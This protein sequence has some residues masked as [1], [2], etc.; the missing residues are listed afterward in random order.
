VDDTLHILSLT[1]DKLESLQKTFSRRD[2]S[3]IFYP[4]RHALDSWRLTRLNHDRS[5]KP[6]RLSS[7][8]DAHKEKHGEARH[9]IIDSAIFIGST[10]EEMPVSVDSP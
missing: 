4:G 7:G 3:V 6:D 10:T 8:S 2:S 5:I 9:R 1:A